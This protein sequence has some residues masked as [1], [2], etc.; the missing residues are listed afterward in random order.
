MF[1][2]TIGSNVRATQRL[3]KSEKPDCYFGGSLFEEFPS[4][5]WVEAKLCDI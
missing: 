3:R 2:P 4:G 5:T 1:E